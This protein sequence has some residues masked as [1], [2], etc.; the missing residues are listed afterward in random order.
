MN[1]LATLACEDLVVGSGMQGITATRMSRDLGRRC[2]MVDRAKSV[3]GVMRPVEM[4]GELVDPGCQLWDAR[5]E[6]NVEFLRSELNLDLVAITGFIESSIAQDGV[7]RRRLPVP[8]FEELPEEIRLAAAA[9][10]ASHGAWPEPDASMQDSMRAIF[11]PDIAGR[12]MDIAARL[13]GR[14]VEWL[15]MA[16]V[17]PMGFT[18]IKLHGCD[19]LE[20]MSEQEAD[21]GPFVCSHPLHRKSDQIVKYFYPVGGLRAFLDRATQWL[22]S[23]L[24]GMVLGETP[25]SLEIRSN[26]AGGVLRTRA[27]AIEFEQLLWCC[28]PLSLAKLLGH[29]QPP[30]E[31]TAPSPFRAF[32]FAARGSVVR[33]EYIQDYRPDSPIFRTWTPPTEMVPHRPDV[34][35]VIVECPGTNTDVEMVGEITERIRTLH[36]LADADIRFLGTQS[37]VRFYPTAVYVRWLHEFVTLLRSQGA[38]VLLPE[39]PLYGRGTIA[40]WWHNTLRQRVGEV[41][42]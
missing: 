1:P 34:Q 6:G 37:Q 32:F 10:A 24:T 17:P 2:G 36:A 12:L 25:I 22:R 40:D 35:Y 42:R 20:R 18:R 39:E 9:S 4:A 28:N 30:R 38:A 23:E 19:E 8:S 7:L 29:A 21:M 11:G 15:A 33:P 31:K 41:A 27:T 3:G 16:A 14:P 13:Y 26:N 5:D